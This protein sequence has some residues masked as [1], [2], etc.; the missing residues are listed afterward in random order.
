MQVSATEK[1]GFYCPLI[2]HHMER[3]NNPQVLEVL[4]ISLIRE[5]E[6]ELV[7]V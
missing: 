3:V 2:N 5:R 6:T 7:A 1:N 4:I